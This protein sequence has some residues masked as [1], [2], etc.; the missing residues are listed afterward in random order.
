MEVVGRV[1]FKKGWVVGWKLIVV[2]GWQTGKE[3]EG[4]AALMQKYLD[5]EKT[6]EPL[7]I[8]SAIALD[9]IKGIVYVEAH[10]EAY[11]RAVRSSRRS[12][13]TEP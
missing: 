2:A 6:A 10:K 1:G 3:R 4:A 12:I 8:K 11:V 13:P 9:N 5:L 7:L